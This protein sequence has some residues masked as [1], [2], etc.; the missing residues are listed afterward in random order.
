MGLKPL[1]QNSG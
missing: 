1:H